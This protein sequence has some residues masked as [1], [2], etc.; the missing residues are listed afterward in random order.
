MVYLL[1]FVSQALFFTRTLLQWVLSER[2]K[3]VLS[4]TIYWVLSI[5]ASYLFCIY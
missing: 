1:G 2:A 5:I 4:P 3:K